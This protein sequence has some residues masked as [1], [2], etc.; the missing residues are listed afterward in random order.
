[1]KRLLIIVILTLLWHSA[2]AY[3]I[4]TIAPSGQTLY[5]N[6]TENG[7][8][9]TYPEPYWYGF[10]KPEG[11]L[12]IP[13]TITYNGQDYLVIGIDESSFMNCESLTSV[14]LPTSITY[15]GSCAFWFCT[16][17]TD[18]NIPNA[19]REIGMAAFSDCYSLHTITIPNS[20]IRI[21]NGAFWG[22]DTVYY[23]GIA[24]GSPWD[25]TT[26]IGSFTG[27]SENGFIFSDS[28]KTIL[29]KYNGNASIVNIP[30]TVTTILDKAF[31]DCNT[32]T[33]INIPNSVTEIGGWA[34]QDCT[35]LRSI[36][37]QIR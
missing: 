9:V 10:T 36:V 7:V 15:I 35:N 23:S 5:Y 2:Y 8:I 30:N 24:S 19:V 21:G 34:F 1:M 32:I 33:N 11:Y 25:A 16:S 14:S 17:L 28:T 26:V 31:L 18:I 20:V 6:I 37:Y 3:D 29:C 4:E 22:I 13:N 27:Y 12:Q